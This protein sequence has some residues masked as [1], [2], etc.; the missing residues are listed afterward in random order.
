MAG[1]FCASGPAFGEILIPVRI[2]LSLGCRGPYLGERSVTERRVRMRVLRRFFG[3]WA[4]RRWLLLASCLSVL[5]IAGY[6]GH[7]VAGQI[8]IHELRDGTERWAD[9]L[10]RRF[11]AR[12]KLNAL[13]EDEE[14][15]T[16]DADLMA[17]RKR[18]LDALDAVLHS[19]GIYQVDL[20]NGDCYCAVSV[21]S[22]EYYSS[23][24]PPADLSW[25]HRDIEVIEHVISG[26]GAHMTVPA[27]GPQ[28]PVDRKLATEVQWLGTPQLQVID[29]AVAGQPEVFGV[30]YFPFETK[31]G[32]AYVLRL[33]L[34]MQTAAAFYGQLIWA[35]SALAVASTWAAAW[36]F[37]RNARHHQAAQDMSATRARFL[38][39]YDPLTGML[40]R[41]GFDF[42]VGP[43]LEQAAQ[44]PGLAVRL[45]VV[46]IDKFND[47]NGYYGLRT[48]DE[49]LVG[50]AELLTGHFG[51]DAVIARLGGDGFV[52]ASLVEISD[53]FEEASPLPTGFDLLVEEGT[54]LLD[55]SVSGGVAYYPQDGKVLPELYQAA[56]L[57][58][59]SAKRNPQQVSAEYDIA[60][61]EALNTRI[62][63]ANGVRGALD[64]CELVPFYQPLVDAR[65]GQV[66]GFESLVRWQHA[67]YGILMP[68]DI[69][70]ALED[71][72]LLPRICDHMIDQILEDLKA[73]HQ[74]ELPYFS[75]G[76]NVSESDLRRAGFV[77][78]LQLKIRKA[79]LVNAQIALEITET[80]VSADNKAEL[81]PKLND[82]RDAGFFIGLDDF[83]TGYS[84]MTVLK[85][86][87]ATAVKIDQSF[88]SGI[89]HNKSDQLIVRHL[90]PLA[91]D[92]GYRV[93]AEGVESRAQYDLLCS[94]G[95]DLI[96]GWLFSK[97]VP[98]P[99]VPDLVRRLNN[100]LP[101]ARDPDGQ[102]QI[103]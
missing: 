64:R 43:L 4:W 49:V 80:A 36:L 30:A 52:V 35:A 24:K 55:V 97:A 66:E 63:Q 22:F 53:N 98:A 62:W 29:Q 83:G 88:I 38:A 2:S 86:V 10:S 91:H 9:F 67:D 54:K 77:D 44:D 75:I 5:A 20:I 28:L 13:I 50:L 103:S 81:M 12:D 7:R 46:D 41:N 32:E 37:A 26:Q 8:M 99:E 92:L 21:G 74:A 18:V 25:T 6:V 73:W 17:A 79:G 42:R 56:D 39:E 87:P 40:N 27:K 89:C 102:R 65:T 14:G 48:G 47:I 101:W 85:E 51:P 68:A 58:L 100:A 76:L 3:W 61:S 96:Q 19:G 23:G 1:F 34:D 60:M 78:T 84:S 69:S 95:V 11:E 16:R 15:G 93:V 59:Q 57:A 70:A 31:G 45:I 72:Q 33:L 71:P 94:L 82:L 90:V